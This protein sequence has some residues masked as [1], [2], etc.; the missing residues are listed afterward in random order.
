MA[1]ILNSLPLRGMTMNDIWASMM[2]PNCN[3]AGRM[4][5]NLPFFTLLDIQD[6]EFINYSTCTPSP[7]WHHGPFIV[8]DNVVFSVIKFSA[9]YFVRIPC[10]SISG[11][12]THAGMAPSLPLAGIRY[13]L[14]MWMDR[15]SW[16]SLTILGGCNLSVG[17]Y[18][19]NSVYTVAMFSGD[20]WKVVVLQ[21]K[22]EML[23]QRNLARAL[24]LWVM[25]YLACRP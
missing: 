18:L 16:I 6:A 20:F 25:S 12:I 15:L 19:V 9:A 4:G 7:P 8:G 22:S 14:E 2:S 11:P 3:L 1:V 21:P 5:T 23:W 17:T 10:G 24:D 13:W